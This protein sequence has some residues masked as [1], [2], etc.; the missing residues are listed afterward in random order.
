MVSAG[1]ESLACSHG[2]RVAARPRGP[3]AAPRPADVT[4]ASGEVDLAVPLD[5]TYRVDAS[6]DSGDERVLVPVDRASDRVLRVDGDTGDVT[7]R[8]SR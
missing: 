2:H 7:V 4:T 1:C 6:T 5:T 3:P 8:P